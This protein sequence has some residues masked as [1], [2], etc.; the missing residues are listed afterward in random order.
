M[1]K[2]YLKDSHISRITINTC[3]CLLLCA[4]F[5]LVYK[6]SSSLH[7]DWV[8][9][10]GITR[11]LTTAILC[12]LP[13]AVYL[14]P[15]AQNR[16]SSTDRII[17]N[18]FKTTTTHFCLILLSTYLLGE[19]LPSKS[20]FLSTFVVF[21]ILTASGRILFFKRATKSRRRGE[22]TSNIILIGN[23]EEIHNLRNDLKTI[24]YGIHIDG[25]F[26]SEVSEDICYKGLPTQALEYIQ[27]QGEHIDAVY[28]STDSLKKEENMEL[29]RLCA[30]KMIRF[31]VVPT[32]AGLIHHRMHITQIGP[33]LMLSTETAPLQ[34]W[35]NRTFKRIADLIISGILLLT[36]FPIIYII[37]AIIT[38][39]QSPGPI[40]HIQKQAGLRGKTFQ[41]INFRSEPFLSS[42]HKDS[43]SENI[44][45][46][47]LFGTFMHKAGIDK[48]PQFINVFLGSMSIVGPQPRTP[49][50]AEVYQQALHHYRIQDQAKPG[51]TGWDQIQDS[52]NTPQQDRLFEDQAL[53]NIWYLENWSF[54]LDLRIIA[55]SC[56]K[57]KMRHHTAHTVLNT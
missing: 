22:K 46:P 41:K 2:K 11:Y 12:Y 3:D 47:F 33:S 49:E 50:Q 4:S 24:D 38:K 39:C 21:T 35:T 51:I 48:L 44:P 29:Y 10:P 25:L 45:K 14:P 16:T 20:F 57:R 53:S 36:A 28:C 30:D 19:S 15:I 17:G 40:L 54:W 6:F 27:Q 34:A 56:F 23:G 9:L 1:S 7:L 13:V 26:T 31:Y 52:E 8:T 5:F 32:F 42:E 55:S 18:V 37:V 43:D